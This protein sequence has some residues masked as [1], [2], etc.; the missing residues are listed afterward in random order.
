MKRAPFQVLVLPF[1]CRKGKSP[2]YAIFRRADSGV[3]QGIA[4]GGES[5]ESPLESARREAREEGGISEA[6][7]YFSLESRCTIPVVNI[8]G[9][10][11][12][13]N[14][15]VIPEYTFGVQMT[16]A[17][18]TLSSEHS[19]YRW[20]SYAVA[21]RL[22]EWNSNKNALWELDTRIKKHK[23]KGRRARARLMPQTAQ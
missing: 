9:F 11:W 21:H 5:T 1:R 16:S 22:L 6:N 7:S 8:R 18:I 20:T 14:V 12:G 15:L 13:P 23:L 19:E 10:K 2:L 17:E 4:G 3:W